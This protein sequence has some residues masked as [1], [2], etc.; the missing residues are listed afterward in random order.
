MTVIKVNVKKL[1]MH[2]QSV[3]HSVEIQCH[4]TLSRINLRWKETE[5]LKINS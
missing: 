5:K 1:N 4:N 2:T 3:R